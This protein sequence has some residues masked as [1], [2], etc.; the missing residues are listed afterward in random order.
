MSRTGGD[1]DEIARVDLD[2]VD[3]IAVVRVEV[4]DVATPDDEAHLVL[5]VAVLLVELVEHFLKV[6][7][8]GRDV[9]DIGGDVATPFLER[10]DLRLVGGEDLLRP[11]IAV[12]A[13]FDRPAL[14]LDAVR[15]EEGADRVRIVDDAV[16]GGNAE[17]CHNFDEE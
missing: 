15:K 10:G 13:A 6:R 12:D 5:G 3:R 7:Q 16:F 17:E 14:V 8:G 11:G 4:K 9:D 2:R 1:V